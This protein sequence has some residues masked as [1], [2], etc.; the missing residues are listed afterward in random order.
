LELKRIR[1]TL[2]E[3]MLYLVLRRH[4]MGKSKM[5]PRA[6]QAMES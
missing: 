2:P 4:G 3:A 1:V 5:I 6:K